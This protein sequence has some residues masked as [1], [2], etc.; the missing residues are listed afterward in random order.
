MFV[1]IV[2][3]TIIIFSMVMMM[4]MIMMVIKFTTMIQIREKV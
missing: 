4:K 2:I 3:K 1:T